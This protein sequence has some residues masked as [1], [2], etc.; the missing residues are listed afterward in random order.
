MIDECENN[1]GVFVSFVLLRMQN[2][3]WKNEDVKG[4][5]VV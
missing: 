1:T 5:I 3:L 4:S 2:Q